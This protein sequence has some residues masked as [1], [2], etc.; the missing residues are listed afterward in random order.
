MRRLGHTLV[1]MLYPDPRHKGVSQALE[2]IRLDRECPWTRSDWIALVI[3]S[4][5][6]AAIIGFWPL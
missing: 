5:I 3:L 1:N 4:L 2:E 6:I